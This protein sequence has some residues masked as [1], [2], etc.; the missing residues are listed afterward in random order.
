MSRN[1]Y[2]QDNK[3]PLLRRSLFVF[4]DV[5][6][7]STFMQEA[8]KGGTQSEA[9]VKVHH[10]LRMGRG[11]IDYDLTP[12][13]ADFIKKEPYALK[14]FTDN[15]VIGWPIRDDAE[16]ELGGM[17][18]MLTGFQMQLALEGFFVRGA[19]ALGDCYVD[20]IVVFGDA[21]E[22]AYRAE[23]SLA[24]D[25]R[26]ILTTGVVEA[27]KVHLS[28]YPDPRGAP[29]VKGI[30]RDADGQW[31]INYL[32]AILL[33]EEEQGP[34]YEDLNRHKVIVEEKLS[35]YKADPPIWSKYAWVAGYHNYFCEQYPEHFGA[36]YKIDVQLFRG[37]LSL[38]V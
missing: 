36:E 16:S 19:L 24:R 10:A 1:P 14:A 9:L 31:F 25:P 8:Q 2:H 27:T 20:D 38:I 21:L 30:L 29:H 37:T 17:L 33:G 32:Q 11:W 12:E 26:I 28:Y 4:M 34:Y 22:E 6:G 18:S 3:A 35:R 15:V 7:Y 5:L 13:L 23:R